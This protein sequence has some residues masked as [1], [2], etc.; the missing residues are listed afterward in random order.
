[1]RN[2]SAVL[3]ETCTVHVP[4][5]SAVQSM[6]PGVAHLLV[7][8]ASKTSVKGAMLPDIARTLNRT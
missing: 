1:M 8:P 3:E 4:V 7:P 5:L 6:S 2:D